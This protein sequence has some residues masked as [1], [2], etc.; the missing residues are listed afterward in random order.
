VQGGRCRGDRAGLLGGDTLPVVTAAETPE[1]PR[2]IPFEIALGLQLGLGPVATGFLVAGFLSAGAL[3]FHWAAASGAIALEEF[4][5][6]GFATRA[7]LIASLA[8]GYVFFA[9]R[10]GAIGGYEDVQALGLAPP[11]EPESDEMYLAPADVAVRSRGSGFLGVLFFLFILELPNWLADVGF[12]G[13]WR[14]FHVLAYLQGV[15]LLFF[16]V[17]GR[18][19][20]L[21]LRGM[22]G[23]AALA[24][25]EIGIDLLDLA[26][27]AVFGRAAVRNCLLWLVSFSL[28]SLVFLNPELAFLDSLSVFVPV[29]LVSL[30][31]A[32]LALWLPLRS[33]HARVSAKKSE[34]LARVD[35]ALRGDAGALEGSRIE[36]WAANARLAD[37]L[38]YRRYLA[39]IR[40]WPFE[41]PTLARVALFVLIPVGSWVGGALVERVV[42]TLL[43]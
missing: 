34:E 2:Q 27:L 9:T 28:G 35:A 33:V 41:G 20:Y 29:F 37:L 15:G 43:R 16:F 3:L 12:F 5:P 32:G 14:S 8:T 11:G 19:A 31:I 38:S 21:S 10:F 30:T 26:P 13:A 23:L 18:A 6:L 25:G 7:A 22:R 39:D 36:H 42:E 1:P 4:A 24:D 40:T 17:A